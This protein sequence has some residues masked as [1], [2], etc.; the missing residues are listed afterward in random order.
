MEDPPRLEPQ[1]LVEAG[2]H[3]A[4]FWVLVLMVLFT[5]P[6]SGNISLAVHGRGVVLL[7]VYYF[8]WARARFQGPKVMGA[9][10]ELTEL[11]REFEHAA[12]ELGDRPRLILTVKAIEGRPASTGRPSSDPTA[13]RHQPETVMSAR[14]QSPP[15]RSTRA[16]R[17]SRR[18][19]AT[20]GSTR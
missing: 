3:V 9:E 16:S 20:A 18:W 8:G 12:E 1:P 4:V 2:R 5:F 15:R 6:T 13:D 10:A 11:E 19:S 14:H 17:S 7:L